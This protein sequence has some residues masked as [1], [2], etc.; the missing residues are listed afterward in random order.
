MR[1]ECL[2]LRRFQT[3]SQFPTVISCGSKEKQKQKQGRKQEVEGLVG[4]PNDIRTSESRSSFKLNL[5][6]GEQ[7]E[8]A[9]LHIQ[10]PRERQPSDGPFSQI[11]H[12]F[13]TIPAT[14]SSLDSLPRARGCPGKSVTKPLGLLRLP[15][16]GES[17]RQ[18]WRCERFLLQLGLPYSPPPA[19][20]LG[21]RAWQSNVAHGNPC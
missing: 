11:I 8:D 1:R 16:G 17:S 9:D 7:E 18:I 21:R 13:H 12:F 14:P 10:G 19:G 4:E 5:M 3:P 6:R 2:F 20:A 15:S